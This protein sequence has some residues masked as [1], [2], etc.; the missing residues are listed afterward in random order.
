VPPIVR[1][2]VWSDGAVRREACATAV[3]QVGGPGGLERERRRC[4]AALGAARGAALDYLIRTAWIERDI[5]RAPTS[6]ARRAERFAARRL[7]AIVQVGLVRTAE[8]GGMTELQLR[9]RVSRDAALVALAEH[10]LGSLRLDRQSLVKY[11][12]RNREHLGTPEAREI[13]AVITESRSVALR[14]LEEARRSDFEAVVRRHSVDRSRA[15]GGRMVIDVRNALPGLRT[16][17]FEARPGALT[18]P[19]AVRGVWWVF[20]VERQIKPRART[21]QEAEA[22]IRTALRGEREQ[23]HVYQMIELLRRRY[24]ATTQCLTA[25]RSSECSR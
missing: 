15:S 13:R 24:G 21:L 9:G 8:L 12:R 6:V 19:V 10:N 2:A 7:A 18:G 17:V 22:Q 14:A 11:Y 16:A 20:K 4:R 25:V 3:S 23:A 5:D 1:A